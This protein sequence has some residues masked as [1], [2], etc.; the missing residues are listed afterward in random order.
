MRSQAAPLLI[1]FAL[2]ALMLGS[3]A[4]AWDGARIQAQARLLPATAQVKVAQLLD[5]LGQARSQPVLEQLS[6]VNDFFNQ[7]V[8]W[9]DDASVWGV[10]DYW[11]APLEMLGKGAGDCEDLA[12]GKYFSLLGLGVEASS[13]RLVYVRA[14]WQGRPQAHMV[15]AWYDKPD[16]EPWILDNLEPQIKRAGARPDLAPVFSFNA[17]GLWQGGHANPMQSAGSPLTRL[18]IWREALAKARAEG[19]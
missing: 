1:P 3:M 5:V 12:M 10:P 8:T 18:T 6:T 4:W 2:A 11:A 17:Q 9:K 15:L 19:F 13:L 7:N 14:Q 16:G